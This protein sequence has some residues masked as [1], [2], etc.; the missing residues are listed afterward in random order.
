[1]AIQGRL[2]S[3]LEKM[4]MDFYRRIQTRQRS[5]MCFLSLQ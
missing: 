1:M 2:E 4:D 5:G 3:T